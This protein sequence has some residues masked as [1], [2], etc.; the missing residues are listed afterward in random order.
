M[1]DFGAFVISL[2]FELHWGVR[3]HCRPG[4]AYRQTAAEGRRLIPHI[5]DLFEEFKISATWATVGMLF[6]RSRRELLDSSP[7]VRPAYESPA[8]NPHL[9]PV[10]ES[11]DDDPLHYA[12]GIIRQIRSRPGQEIASHTFSHYCCLEPGHCRQSFAADIKAAIA[13]AAKHGVSLRSIVFPR[14]QINP[15]LLDILPS[16]GIIAYRG[17]AQ[18]WMYGPARKTTQRA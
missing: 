7:D 16:L 12:P 4:A 6:S 10:G 13:L 3:D 11:E 9:E 15:E 14:D 5:L 2:D 1:P 18:S 17:A 8:L